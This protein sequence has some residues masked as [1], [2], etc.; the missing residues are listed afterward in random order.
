MMHGQKNIKIHSIIII[1]S[2]F[3]LNKFFKAATASQGY[4]ITQY[5][6]V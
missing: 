2:L 5:R 3:D 1:I 6:S 4:N